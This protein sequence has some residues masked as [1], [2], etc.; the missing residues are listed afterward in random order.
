[1][2]YI[3]I[4]TNILTGCHVLVTN[5]E[6]NASCRPHLSKLDNDYTYDIFSRQASRSKNADVITSGR[7]GFCSSYRPHLSKLDNDYTH[8]IFTRHA[9]KVDDHGRANIRE[10]CVFSEKWGNKI[11]SSCHTICQGPRQSRCTVKRIA[12]AYFLW[13][14]LVRV[15]GTEIYACLAQALTV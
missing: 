6:D 12:C 4:C 10:D 9:F 13:G 1:M 11:P 5:D 3:W 7:N 8:D 2:G 14:Y 15:I